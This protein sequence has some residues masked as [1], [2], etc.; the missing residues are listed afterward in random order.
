MDRL[1]FNFVV[2]AT[3][4]G[5]TNKIV[6]TF[7]GTQKNRNFIMPAEYQAMNL[8]TILEKTKVYDRIKN[9]LKKGT[10]KEKCG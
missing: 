1:R 3:E 7:G 10:R 5:K 8:H 9:K 4:N 6:L 2:K